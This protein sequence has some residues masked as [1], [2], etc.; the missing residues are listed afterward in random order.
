MIR[1]N[2]GKYIIGLERWF[3]TV[4]ECYL[5]VFQYYIEFIEFLQI[6]PLVI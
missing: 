3:Q 5:P 1:D 2:R 6:L 4:E